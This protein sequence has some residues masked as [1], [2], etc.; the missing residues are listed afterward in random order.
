MNNVWIPDGYKD[1]PVDRA[2][3][4]ARLAESLDAIF[5][6]DLPG[7]QMLDAVECKLFGIGTES[8]VV[9]SHEFYMG[10]ADYDVRRLPVLPVTHPNGR[11]VRVAV[12]L[13]ETLKGP[14][15]R[16]VDLSLGAGESIAIVGPSGSG[17]STL[18]NIAGALDNLL[19]I[20]Q[21][22]RGFADDGARK[23][24]LKLFD[25]LGDDPAVTRYRAR[26]FNL[27]H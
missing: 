22:D 8:Y 19:L 21:K 3:P 13:P 7:E 1:M 10:Y 16:G 14:V 24:L 27:L 5:A 2:G 15:L 23:A 20:M 18:L 4:R 17:K 12:E 9:G 25:M 26:M 11:R 6:E